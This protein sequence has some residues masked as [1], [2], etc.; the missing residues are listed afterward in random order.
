VG[1][2]HLRDGRNGIYEHA[3]TAVGPGH[4]HSE[5]VGQAAIS[6]ALERLD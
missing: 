3:A 5:T 6:L 1:P 4:A 2:A